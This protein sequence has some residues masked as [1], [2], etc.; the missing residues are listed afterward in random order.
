[1]ALTSI[2]RK[3]KLV[4]IQRNF[5]LCVALVA[6]LLFMGPASIAAAQTA[7]ITAAGKSAI[8]ASPGVPFA[9]ATNADVTVVEG[10]A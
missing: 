9:G 10:F 7:A 3:S 2:A 4:T 8:L 5:Q 6:S 1:M